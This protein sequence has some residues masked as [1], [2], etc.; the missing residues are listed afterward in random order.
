MVTDLL[1]KLN[2]S[3]FLNIELNTSKSKY[4][5]YKNLLYIYKI[6]LN[7]QNKGKKYKDI[8]VKIKNKIIIEGTQLQEERADSFAIYTMIPKNLWQELDNVDINEGNLQVFSNKY[9]IPM[10]F[11]VG[12]LAKNKKI[13]YSSKIYQT[14]C[15][16]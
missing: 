12:R 15:K 14:Y 11:I 5:M 1:Y 10:S 6:I 9:K 13:K 3:T 8:I 16:S 2:D 7:E 4:L